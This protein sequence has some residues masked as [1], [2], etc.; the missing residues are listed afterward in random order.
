ME[1]FREPAQQIG[2]CFNRHPAQQGCKKDE[3]NR[4]PEVRRKTKNGKTNPCRVLTAKGLVSV[5]DQSEENT[6][7]Y[8][9]VLH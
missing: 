7:P 4:E 9:Q 2:C 8:L 3:G 5:T 6:N 1:Q